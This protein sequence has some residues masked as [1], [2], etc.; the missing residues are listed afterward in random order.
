MNKHNIL[1]I[2]LIMAQEFN[3]V[4]YIEGQRG[5]QPTH[6]DRIPLLKLRL[7]S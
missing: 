4:A 1:S 3:G 2:S 5:A 6:H 7:K